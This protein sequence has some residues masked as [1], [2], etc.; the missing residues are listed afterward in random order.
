[1]TLLS[2]GEALIRAAQANGLRTLFGLPGAQIYPLFDAAAR[3][4]V[5]LIVPRHEQAAGFMAMGYARALGEPGVLAVVPG[6]GV[7]NASAALCTAMGTCTPIV[8]LLGQVPAQYLGKGRGHLHEL[9]DQQATLRTLI[10]DALR[11]E[12]ASDASAVVNR[13]FALAQSGR[14]G[15]V[16]VEMC[17]DTMAAAAPAETLPPPPLPAPPAADPDEVARAAALIAR[18]RKPMIMCG[19]GARGAATAVR[20]LAALLN[21]PVTAFRSGRGIVPEDHPLGVAAVA[22]RE[23]WDDVDLLIGI[24]SRL[25]M[26]YGRWASMMQYRPAPDDGRTLIRIDIDPAEMTRFRPHVGIVAEA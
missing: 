22:A 2:G 3:L 9:L 23:L 21:A 13:A 15:P 5:R 20:E 7:L 19:A 24:G 16:S 25:E 11:A 1:Q 6:P 26:P 12:G 4:G 14:P 18:A 10:K 8:C 17:W